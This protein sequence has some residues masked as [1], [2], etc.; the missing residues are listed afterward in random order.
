MG[1]FN[2]V[3]HVMN[4]NL[5][6]LGRQKD[7]P[8]ADSIKHY[9]DIADR[10][11]KWAEK[12]MGTKRIDPALYHDLA[13]Q[14]IDTRISRGLSA[15]TIHTDVAALS[16]AMGVKMNTFSYPMRSAPTKG[17]G[18]ETHSNEKIAR[19]EAVKDK[20][21]IRMSEYRDLKEHDL[22]ERDG[23]LYVIVEQ[24]KGGKYQ[25]Q[26]IRPEYEKDVR[27]FFKDVRGKDGYIL[28]KEER[29]AAKD[30]ATHAGRREYAREMYEY[31]R[32]LPEREKEYFRHELEERFKENP[33]KAERNSYK[34]YIERLD[35]SP[36]Y[37]TRGSNRDRLL[38]QGRDTCFDREALMMTSV[39]C[40]AHYR[41]DVT[42]KNYLI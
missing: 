23:R 39:F 28:S 27:E 24:G 4:R 2:K 1:K 35:R 8:K 9:K 3:A 22:L 17:R 36:I 19:L 26:F 6:L 34:T 42:V 16:K 33:I 21:G 13:Q 32:T 20:I 37:Y 25:E 18:G 41:E 15:D 7:A 31:F 11:S 30:A 29:D 40:L 38:E 5:D 12:E 10:F 14:Y